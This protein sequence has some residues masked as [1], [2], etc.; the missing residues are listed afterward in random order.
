MEVLAI[1]DFVQLPKMFDN[2]VRC[3]GPKLLKCVVARE[4]GAG[5]DSAVLSGFNIVLHIANEHGLCGGELI[6]G[7]D[8]VNFFAFIPNIDIRLLQVSIKTGYRGLHHEMVAMNRAEQ[9]HAQILGETK[10][11]E[12]VSVRQWANRVLHL[13]EPAVKPV[14]QLRQGNVRY[15]TFVELCKRK[16]KLGAK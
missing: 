4:H 11:K 8:F 3:D 12:F 6:F 15:V 2:Q 9:K 14:F 7:Q 13:T 1:Q 16:A 5:M 10:F